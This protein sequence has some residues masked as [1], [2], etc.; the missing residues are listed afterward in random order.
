MRSGAAMG[1]CCAILGVVFASRVEAPV[2]GTISLRAELPVDGG[3]LGHAWAL[4]APMEGVQ[5]GLT[6][7]YGLYPVETSLFNRDTVPPGARGAVYNDLR[8]TGTTRSPTPWMRGNWRRRS[9]TSSSAKQPAGGSLGFDA[10]TANGMDFIRNLAATATI[11]LPR[12]V[13]GFGIGDAASFA[14]ALRQIG[15]GGALA[16]EPSALP[17]HP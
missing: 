8:R 7:S 5:T 3:A 2:A 4:I 17:A 6:L 14:D 13:N 9:S 16:A 12:A 1:C 15:D 11:E 10:L